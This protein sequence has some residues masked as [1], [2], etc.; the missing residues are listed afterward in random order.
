MY[1]LAFSQSPATS[2]ER[3]GQRV[4]RLICSP[5]AQKVQVIDV[6]PEPSESARDWGRLICELEG[7]Q[8]IH[9]DRLDSGAIRIGW[10][11]HVEII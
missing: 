1:P 3:L 7:T 5:H 2:Y 11:E 9:V 6:M 10:R 8:G 4:Q